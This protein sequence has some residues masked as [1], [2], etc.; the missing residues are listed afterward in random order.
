MAPSNY[1]WNKASIYRYVAK[2]KNDERYKETNRIRQRKY[3]GWIR[4][5]KQFL[6]IL[7]E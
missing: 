3:D 5:K 7:R 4:I 1:K 2:H 6:A